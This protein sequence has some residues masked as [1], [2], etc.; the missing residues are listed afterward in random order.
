MRNFN[1]VINYDNTKASFMSFS[2]LMFEFEEISEIILVF[3]EAFSYMCSTV[4]LLQPAFLLKFHFF[5][6]VF[7]FLRNTSRLLLLCFFYV[8]HIFCIQGSKLAQT[9]LDMECIDKDGCLKQ[10]RYPLRTA[11]QWLGPAM[12]L[13]HRAIKCINININSTNDN[14]IIDHLS[15]KILHG[16]NFQVKYKI[17]L[18]YLLVICNLLCY[19]YSLQSFIS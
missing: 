16:G 6:L 4:L 8:R 13:I 11:A 3:W 17:D 5:T 7:F 1:K 10:D 12:D 19:F 15:E 14:P 9:K 18:Q 2:N